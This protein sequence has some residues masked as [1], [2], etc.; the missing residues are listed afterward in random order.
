MG[1]KA[2]YADRR[3]Q[4][5]KT[6]RKNLALQENRLKGIDEGEKYSELY[7]YFQTSLHEAIRNWGDQYVEHVTNGNFKSGTKTIHDY[8]YRLWKK[9]VGE[10]LERELKRRR[11]EVLYPIKAT[12][13][14]DARPKKKL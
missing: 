3:E 9:F 7:Q 6:E 8:D 10:E 14:L 13:L 4:A 11:H 2:D 1:T 12:S 5:I